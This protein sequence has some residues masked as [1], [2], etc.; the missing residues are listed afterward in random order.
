MG[1][2]LIARNPNPYVAA[3]WPVQTAGYVSS[4]PGLT[5]YGADSYGGSG[6]DGPDGRVTVFFLNDYTTGAAVNNAVSGYTRF[7]EGNAA[8]YALV[9]EPKILVP[10][11]AGTMQLTD[12]WR[13]GSYSDIYGQFAPGNGL[14]LRGTQPQVVES[15]PSGPVSSHQRWWHVDVRIG[16]DAS[17]IDASQRDSMRVGGI[18]ATGTTTPT[19]LQFYNCFFGWS[20]DEVVDGYSGPDGIMFAYCVFAEALDKSLNNKGTIVQHNYGPLIGGGYR[21]YR[22]CFQ[23]NLFAHLGGRQPMIGALLF[24][25]ANNI[26]YNPGNTTFDIAQGV[27]IVNDYDA[28]D[29][30]GTPN[31]AAMYSNIVGN[32]FIRGPQSYSSF[33]AICCDPTGSESTTRPPVGSQGWI[34]NN[35]VY[36]WT[37]TDQLSLKSGTFPSGWDASSLLT[38]AWPSGWGTSLEGI[39]SI[40]AGPDPNDYTTA[41]I[42]TFASLMAESVGPRPGSRSSADRAGVIANHVLARLLGTGDEGQCVNSVS[43]TEDPSGWPNILLRFSPNA[44]GYPTMGSAT[45]DPFNPDST[46]HAAVPLNGLAPDDR[47]LSS[48]TFSNGLSKVGYT[49]LEAWAIEQ[50][51]YVGGK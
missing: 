49:A 34:T 27:R 29:I 1:G 19:Y 47:V 43:G 7:R 17:G 33:Q 20:I 15:F 23:R 38:S 24:A 31:T 3:D 45:I 11:K 12:D 46:W 13:V 18:D 2:F 35:A 21:A 4:I 36:G 16:D 30:G 48:G 25:Y 37:Y 5:G 50:H 6:R 39:K 41:E 22:A 10:T 28:G 51:Y 26:I 8:G 42:L 32:A 40:G 14:L 44:G 9:S